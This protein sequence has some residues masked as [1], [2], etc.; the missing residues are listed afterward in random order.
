MELLSAYERRAAVKFPDNVPCSA[1][2]P[3]QQR[4]GPL[5]NKRRRVQEG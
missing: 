2:Q 5:D 4:P 1:C 3:C